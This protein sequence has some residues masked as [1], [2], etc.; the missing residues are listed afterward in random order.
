[1]SGSVVGKVNTMHDTGGTIIFRAS[2]ERVI[3]QEGGEIFSND[4]IISQQSSSVEP[5]SFAHSKKNT[6]E[7]DHLV[8]ETF[9]SDLKENVTAEIPDDIVDSHTDFSQDTH[10]AIDVFN[11]NNNT[12]SQNHTPQTDFLP[13]TTTIKGGTLTVTTE[14]FIVYTPYSISDNFTFPSFTLRYNVGD[15]IVVDNEIVG[16]GIDG[17]HQRMATS[18]LA[19][20][21]DDFTQY[22]S[23]EKTDN[24]TKYLL[25]LE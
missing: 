13:Y 5:S 18:D 8:V 3:A 9:L 7:F 6:I 14:G 11:D 15:F 4:T 17:S 22:L 20:F 16:L 24:N 10:V 23:P 19:L 21:I 12:L 25:A 2:G 1:M